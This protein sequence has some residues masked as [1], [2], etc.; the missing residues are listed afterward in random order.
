MLHLLNYTGICKI[1][2][3]VSGGEM[4]KKYPGRPGCI[5]ATSGK[6]IRY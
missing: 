3:A 5:T 2:L 6:L 1:S 4:V